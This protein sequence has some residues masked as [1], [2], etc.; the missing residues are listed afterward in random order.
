MNLLAEFTSITLVDGYQAVLTLMPSSGKCLEYQYLYFSIAQPIDSKS[1]KGGTL[2]ERQ[3]DLHKVLLDQPYTGQAKLI[4]EFAGSGAIKKASDYPEGA[5]LESENECIEVVIPQ[6]VLREYQEV[7]AIQSEQPVFIPVCSQRLL[8][9]KIDWTNVID[10]DLARW[11]LDWL[12]RLL[13][14]LPDAPKVRSEP[15]GWSIIARSDASIVDDFS[16]S[17]SAKEVV[18]TYKDDQGFQIGQAYFFQFMLQLAISKQCMAVCLNGSPRFEYRGIHLDVVRHFFDIDSITHWLDLFALF[19]FNHFHWHLT[20]DD[21]WRLA[22]DAYPDLTRIGAWRGKGESLPPQ[23]GSGYKR[24]GG[25]YTQQQ[26]RDL[27]SHASSLKIT[28]IPEMDLPGHARALLKS[29]PELVEPEDK[30][31]YRSVQHHNDN[32]LNPALASTYTVLDVLI[33]EWSQIFPG[34]LFHIGADEIPKGVWSESPVA[35][36]WREEHQATSDQLLGH[37]VSTMEAT[38]NTKQKTLAGWEEVR[39]GGG[40]TTDAWIFSWQGIEAGVAAAEAGHPVVMTPAQ[41]CYLD[42][43]VTEHFADPGYWWAGTVNL[44]Q[45]YQY[46]PTLGLSDTASKNIRGVQYCLWS[47]LVQ[48]PADAEFMWFPRLFAGAQV[49][50][51]NNTNEDYGVFFDSVK[52]WANVLSHLGVAVRSEKIGW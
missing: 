29:L 36:T 46:D 22:S 48:S 47:E 17:V 9:E 52:G 2:I 15:G 23:M 37:W 20:D 26:A 13:N 33:D 35:K 38:L 25:F 28:V 43:A 32:V 19:H 39:D 4:V 40:A 45:V 41:H 12:N 44:Q 42:L 14:R 7:E 1:L 49:V 21:G 51:G 8:S 27:V 6:E 30:S 16:L 10:L 11:N 31:Q 50:W 5:F 24:Y 3:G 18:L 34:N